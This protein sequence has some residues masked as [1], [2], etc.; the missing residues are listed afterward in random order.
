M[1]THGIN[2][3]L[4]GFFL[5]LMIL[6]ILAVA[7]VPF[8]KYASDGCFIYLDKIDPATGFAFLYSLVF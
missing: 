1:S 2:K 8:L 3:V 7:I 6:V 5:G 4:N